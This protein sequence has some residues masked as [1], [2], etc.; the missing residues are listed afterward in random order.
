[1]PGAGELRGP[2]IFQ[3]LGP[4]GQPAVSEQQVTEVSVALAAQL[5][6]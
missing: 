6:S 5:A 3:L 4:A 2:R 1:M